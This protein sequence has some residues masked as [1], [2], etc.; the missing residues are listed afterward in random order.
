VITF[1]KIR[2]GTSNTVAISER[3]YEQHNGSIW[4]CT[5]AF[6]Q[7]IHYTLG[8]TGKPA[9]RDELINGT[10]N[11]AVSSWHPGGAQFTLCDGSARFISETIDFPTWRDLG[12]RKDGHPITIP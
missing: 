12:N 6:N 3:E 5:S 2:D 9:N 4:C 7:N 10:Y 11:N 8:D 1:S